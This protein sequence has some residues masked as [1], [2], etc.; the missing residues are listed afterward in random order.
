MQRPWGGDQLG[1]VEAIVA[2]LVSRGGL[3]DPQA[4]HLDF[5]LVAVMS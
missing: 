3:E 4:D 5:S 1:G 2:I